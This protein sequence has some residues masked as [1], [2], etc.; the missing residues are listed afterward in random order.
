MNEQSLTH[1]DKEGSVLMV[2]VGHKPATPRKAVVRAQVQ[3]SPDTF[4]MLKDKALPK[5][6]VL[7]TA[8][9][10]GISAAKETSRLI[11]LCHP[12]FLSF[13][14]VRFYLE[15]SKAMIVVEAEARTNSSTG[16][17]MEALVAA[18]VACMTIYDMCKAVQKDIVINNC[19]LVHK[20]GGRSGVYNSP[21]SPS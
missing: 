9:I 15:E 21:A 20:S 8:K 17:E 18:Q 6:D 4:A 19:R 16:V 10:A 2:D 11:P 12:V 14:D 7:V 3:L 1:L 5:G 13:V